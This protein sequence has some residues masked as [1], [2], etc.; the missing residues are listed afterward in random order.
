[1]VVGKQKPLE[2]L[3]KPN[4]PLGVGGVGKTGRLLVIRC[5][6]SYV[7]VHSSVELGASYGDNC[8]GSL[9]FSR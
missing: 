2:A 8:R 7:A 5:I 3:A 9:L 1:M 4:M 6:Y